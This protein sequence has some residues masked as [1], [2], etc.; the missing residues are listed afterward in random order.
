MGY[1]SNSS[2]R[3]DSADSGVGKL[4]DGLKDRI[5]FLFLAGLLGTGG[6][7]GINA[8]TSEVRSD[9]FT[10][11]QGKAL[12][13]RIR[14]LEQFQALDNQHRVDS[15]AGYSRIRAI[16]Q[17]CTECRTRVHGIEDKLNI[18][19]DDHRGWRRRF[20]GGHDEAQ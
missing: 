14:T 6:G 17:M 15:A 5:I 4:Y 7:L 13:E 18:F 12:E 11:K 10:G 8:Y 9:P 19:E 1:G 16:E 3:N 20:R 2:G